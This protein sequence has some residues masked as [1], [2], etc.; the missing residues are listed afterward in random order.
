MQEQ[1]IRILLIE[2]DEDDYV[3]LRDL[4]SE[5]NHAPY[6]LDWESAYDRGLDKICRNDHDLYLLDY[7]LAER[8]GLE[9]L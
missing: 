6:I 3:L 4:L 5:I 2:D 1:K 8:T 9:L 7:R